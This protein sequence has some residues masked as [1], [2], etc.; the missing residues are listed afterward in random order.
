MGIVR[1]F[2]FVDNGGEGEMEMMGEERMFCW[3]RKYIMDGSFPLLKKIISNLF[4]DSPKYTFF[5]ITI[6]DCQQ[7]FSV[8]WL[9]QILFKV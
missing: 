9:K 1:W 6:K 8:K 3:P 5:L 4:L 7:N 2:F